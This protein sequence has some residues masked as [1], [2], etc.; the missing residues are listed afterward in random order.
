VFR[1]VV[2]I[3]GGRCLGTNVTVLGVKI[4]DADVIVAA[5]AE[6]DCA[7]FPMSDRVV[8]HIHSVDRKML[9]IPRS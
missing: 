9:R 1:I 7:A 8:F 2:E 4:L 3:H 6:K 5:N